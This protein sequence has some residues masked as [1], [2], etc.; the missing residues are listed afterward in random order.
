MTQLELVKIRRR[1]LRLKML[2]GLIPLPV[3]FAITYGTARLTAPFV[4]VTAF[5]SRWW[6]LT[7]LIGTG[8][9]AYYAIGY[10]A[11]SIR[12]DGNIVSIVSRMDIVELKA[13][14]NVLKDTLANGKER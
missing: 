7:V 13:L 4:G 8:L 2:A 12:L 6:L 9:L 11:G 10:W 5:G 14:E 3:L 1:Q